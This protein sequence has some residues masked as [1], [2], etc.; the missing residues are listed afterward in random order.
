MWGPLQLGESRGEGDKA[1]P[2]EVP[3]ASGCSEAQSEESITC[4]PPTPTP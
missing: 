1:S 2:W 4:Q 3:W